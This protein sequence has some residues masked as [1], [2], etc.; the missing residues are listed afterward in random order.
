V[1]RRNVGL[2]HWPTKVE[3]K[4]DCVV[5]MKKHTKL[6]S[7]RAEVR[8][9]TRNKCSICN[10]YLRIEKDKNYFAKYHTKLEYWTD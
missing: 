5:R 10:A 7:P 8:H 3:D 9:Q 1:T 2:G 4:R 6:N